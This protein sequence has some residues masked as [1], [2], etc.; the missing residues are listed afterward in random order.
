M[1]Y[2]AADV[3]IDTLHEWVSKAR[4]LAVLAAFGVLIV[5]VI[6]GASPGDSRVIQ[7]TLV[8][9]PGG[10]G[11]PFVVVRADDGKYYIADLSAAQSRGA[12]NVGTRISVVGVEGVRPF[13]V[14][15]S[16]IG[17]GDSALSAPPPTPAIPS[18]AAP[19]SPSASPATIKPPGG[20][21]PAAAAA[22]SWRRVEG[23]VE[24]VSNAELTLRDATGGPVSV[25]VSQLS[26]DVSGVVRPG[27]DVTVFATATEGSDRLVAVGFVHTEPATGA[28]LPR[29]R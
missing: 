11:E 17:A 12:I 7:G 5:P 8:W 13:E 16:I 3:L 4:T 20:A 24:S 14:T 1:A 10:T 29:S 19:A 28:A 9:S 21:A 27:D 22:R 23:K 6:A 26:G 18:A 2:T 15:A 25:D